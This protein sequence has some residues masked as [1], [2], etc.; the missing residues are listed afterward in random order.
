MDLLMM[1]Q[2]LKYAERKH[3]ISALIIISDFV[4][5]STLK[6]QLSFIWSIVIIENIASAEIERWLKYFSLKLIEHW[7]WCHTYLDII[8][9]F[10]IR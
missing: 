8:L 9:S 5:P 6:T 7:I 1:K 3:K 10:S 2:T 4:S